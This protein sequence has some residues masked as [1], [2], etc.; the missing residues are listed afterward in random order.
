MPDNT[1]DVYW[2]DINQWAF[3]YD[4]VEAIQ[5]PPH[6]PPAPLTPTPV[7]IFPTSPP[8]V[9]TSPPIIIPEGRGNMPT[10]GLAPSPMPP[11][12]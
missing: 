10:P 8:V 12:R 2:V 3:G 5:P 11:H 9:P 7:P 4:E 1:S 6:Q